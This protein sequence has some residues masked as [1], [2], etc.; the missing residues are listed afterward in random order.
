MG[1]LAGIP[2][3]A[4]LV[5]IYPAASPSAGECSLRLRVYSC[6]AGSVAARGRMNRSEWQAVS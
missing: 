5:R 6:C 1:A 2:Q 4:R 3:S